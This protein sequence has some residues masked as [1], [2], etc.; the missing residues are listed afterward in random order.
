MKF[1]KYFDLG[2][3]MSSIEEL[4]DAVAEKASRLPAGAWFQ[5]GCWLETQFAENRTPTR[6]DLDPASPDHSVV[7]ERIFS[8]RV[9]NSMA[10]KLAGI[11]KDTPDPPGGAIE[12][13]PET[14]EPTGVLH[15][16]AKALVRNVMPS[17]AD[18][19]SLAGGGVEEIEELA[20]RAMA[21]FVRY[22]ITGTLEAGANPDMCRA[23]RRR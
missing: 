19:G 15:R 14:G 20:G 2:N 16:N 6:K 21:E 8:T 12:R 13:D 7:L 5:G 1:L 18:T 4:T 11:T 22:G 23:L 9:A 10:L 17:G 3:G